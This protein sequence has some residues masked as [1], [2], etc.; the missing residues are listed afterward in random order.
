LGADVAG[1]GGEDEWVVLEEI[2][3]QETE[4]QG[5]GGAS[6]DALGDSRVVVGGDLAAGFAEEERGG[7]FILAGGS[8]GVDGRAGD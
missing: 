8:A 7:A 2:A 6:I 4:A 1:E 3:G 5:R